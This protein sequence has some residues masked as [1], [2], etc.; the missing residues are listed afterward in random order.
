MMD[1]KHAPQHDD[2]QKKQAIEAHEVKEVIGFLKRYGKLIGT[3]VLAATVTVI[4]SRAYAHH[5]ASKLVNAEQ[6]LMNARTP[7]ELAAVADEYSSTP[8]APVALLDLAKTLFNAGDYAAARAQY[9]NFLKKY[10][11][12]EMLPIAEFGLAYC[13][14]ADG[15]F[16]GAA[17][18]FAGFAEKHTGYL[19]PLAIL[20]VARCM[21]QAGRIDEA[22]IVLEDFLAE[23]S[24][25]PWAGNAESALLSLNETARQN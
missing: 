25:T 17:I 18:E 5:K 20:S 4:A 7:Q 13:T 22:R 15:D 14:E 19:H 11:K 12:H 24:G 9:E 8:A 1:Q 10:K 3:G 6:A 16:N 2:L 23:H 21:E